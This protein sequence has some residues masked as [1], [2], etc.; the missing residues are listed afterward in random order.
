MKANEANGSGMSLGVSC[1]RDL[2]IKQAGSSGK[3]ML[4]ASGGGARKDSGKTYP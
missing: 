2:T 3:Q 1:L 4:K